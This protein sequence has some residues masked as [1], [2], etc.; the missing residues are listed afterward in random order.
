MT[1]AFDP[2]VFL[3]AQTTDANE[4]RA[5]L[6]ADNPDSSD[7]LYTAVIGE[8]KTDSGTISKGDRTGQPWISMVVPLKLQLGSAVQA[9]G[10]PA[11]FQLTDRAFLDLTPQ[12]GMDNSK[13]KN[14]Q[15][16]KYRDA[17]GLNKPGEAFA[18]RMLTGRVVKV[19]VAHELYLENIVE[20][21]AQVLPG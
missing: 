15:Q 5:L 9:L 11:E 8:I 7:G 20:K 10:L 21:V 4:K 6:P 1:S 13:G 18:W 16:R 19:K 3:D 17:A 14:N 2:N 12:G